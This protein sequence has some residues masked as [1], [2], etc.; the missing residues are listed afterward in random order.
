MRF[1]FRWAF[2][3]LLMIAVLVVSLVLLKDTL[4]KSFAEYRIRSETGMDVKIGRLET[5]LFSPTL[6]VEHLKLYNRA[7]FGG[8]PFIEVPELHMECHPAPLAIGKLR[9]KLLRVQIDHVNIVESKGGQTN[10]VEVLAGVEYLRTSPHSPFRR[11]EFAGIDLL[12]LSVGKV[13]YTS[14]R[15]PQRPTVIELNV[16]NEIVSDITSMA[17]LRDVMLNLMVRKGITVVK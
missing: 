1:L 14:L 16:R 8:S 13:N 5:G 4:L 6:T 9:F 2:R 7:E 11:W 10:L 17:Q 15:H 3:L 12:N